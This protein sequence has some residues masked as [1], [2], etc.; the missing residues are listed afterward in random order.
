MAIAKIEVNILPGGLGRT[1]VVS[2]LR[3]AGFLFEAC[4]RY[5]GDTSNPVKHRLGVFAFT[6]L[7]E[8]EAELDKFDKTTAG[9]PFT[10]LTRVGGASSNIADQNSAWELLW[11]Q[12]RQYM[13]RQVSDYFNVVGEGNRCVAGVCES[14]SLKGSQW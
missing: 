1:A 12:Q 11:P 6:S 2:S 14:F 7:T 4:L 10:P 9:L 3:G 8:F 13:V 5:S